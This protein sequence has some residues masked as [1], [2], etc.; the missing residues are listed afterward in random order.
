MRSLRYAGGGVVSL[1][2][3]ATPTIG[4]DQALVRIKAS[5]LC[6]SERGA[7]IGGLS[8][9]AGHEAAGVIEALTA[10][11]SPFRVGQLVGL[12]AVTGCGQCDRCGAG[13]ETQCRRGPRVGG[14]WHAEYAV[15]GVRA[16]RAVNGQD[17]TGAA[18]M[19]GDALGVPARVARRF[20]P[21]PGAEVVVIGLGPVGLGHVVVQTFAG[22]RV[23][24]IEPSA[25]RRRQGL[26]L[27]AA[28]VFAPG[29][30]RGRPATVIEC[31]GLPSAVEGAFDLVDSSG[32]VIQSGECQA[33]VRL[34]PSD[35]VVHREVTYTG[36]WFYASE[37]YPYMTGLLD[38]G[39]PLRGLCTHEVAPEDAEAA[40]GDFVRGLTG[41]VVVRW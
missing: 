1:D 38:R 11:G 32:L 16:L 33:P 23:I 31:T 12:A 6:G 5:A 37:D 7:L 3:V 13:R 18:L 8:G 28:E 9:N 27:G 35:L 17:P 2:D 19:S 21:L 24:G 4:A 25:E 30:Y 20:P 39:L 15:V 40:F 29:E 26:A 34:I 10:A 36:S 41:K 14:G 22:A